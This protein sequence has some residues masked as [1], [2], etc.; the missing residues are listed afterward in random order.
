MVGSELGT[1]IHSTESELQQHWCDT[2]HKH[3]TEHILIPSG[4]TKQALP[5]LP[6]ILLPH[7]FQMIPQTCSLWIFKL[8]LHNSCTTWAIFF[9]FFNQLHLE[10]TRRGSTRPDLAFTVKMHFN[11]NLCLAVAYLSWCFVAGWKP[12]ITFF[13]PRTPGYSYLHTNQN[14]I[15]T[16]VLSPQQNN[17]YSQVGSKYFNNVDCQRQGMFHHD[18]LGISRKV[19][20][21]KKWK[22]NK[23]YVHTSTLLSLPVHKM[24]ISNT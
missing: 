8:S 3:S 16:G 11:L 7:H 15:N 10:G 1:L 24:C 4:H 6:G 18:L 20:D 2:A 13:L 12:E 22:Y 14:A 19:W 23:I 9:S 17:L 21:I 5:S